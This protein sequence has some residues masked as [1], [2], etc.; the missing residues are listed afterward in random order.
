MLTLF[1][2]HL[3]HVCFHLTFT[4]FLFSEYADDA[5]CLE[6]VTEPF[7]DNLTQTLLQHFGVQN[8]PK[9]SHSKPAAV[10]SSVTSE[11]SK[12]ASAM[13]PN[14]QSIVSSCASLTPSDK[15]TLADLSRL[16]TE[17]S[18]KLKDIPDGELTVPKLAS[19]TA[20]DATSQHNCLLTAKQLSV[21]DTENNDTRQVVSCYEYLKS[22]V[23]AEVPFYEGTVKLTQKLSIESEQTVPKRCLHQEKIVLECTVQCQL[24]KEQTREEFVPGD[25]YGI[26]T[27]NLLADVYQVLQSALVVKTDTTTNDLCSLWQQLASVSSS[28][29]EPVYITLDDKVSTVQQPY[30]IIN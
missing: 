6:T 24:P 20:S 25:A 3:A 21:G 2:F 15:E 8:D 11:V 1:C 17:P 9:A 28:K 19:A 29:T 27:S 26:Y 12:T 30:L 4:F 18:E 10:S 23:P 22:K 13:L 7:M 16:L 14:R 5:V